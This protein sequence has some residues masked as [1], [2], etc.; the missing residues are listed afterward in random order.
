MFW[1]EYQLAELTT[2]PLPVL[3]TKLTRQ[4]RDAIKAFGQFVVTIEH[5]FPQEV[6]DTPASP[7]KDHRVGGLQMADRLV[8]TQHRFLRNVIDSTAKSLR[9]RDGQSPKPPGSSSMRMTAFASQR[10]DQTTRRGE[11]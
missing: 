9:I 10:V 7:E 2:K 5:A 8:H 4:Q 1:K 3:K 6:A 11:L